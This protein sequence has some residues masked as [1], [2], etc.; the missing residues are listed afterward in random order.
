MIAASQGGKASASVSFGAS[1]DTV[2]KQYALPAAISGLSRDSDSS[3]CGGELPG[4][5]FSGI[6][7][8]QL[9]L[10]RDSFCSKTTEG[11]SVPAD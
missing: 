2:A 9:P 8:T 5:G 3:C 6:G 10:G 7:E 4:E 1:S 11:F